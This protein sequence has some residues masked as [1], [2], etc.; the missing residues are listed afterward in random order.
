MKDSHT[1]VLIFYFLYARTILKVR[2]IE[3]TG[4]QA[5]FMAGN[6]AGRR[7]VAALCL[8]S[9][10]SRI[11]QVLRSYC[12]DTGLYGDMPFSR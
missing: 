6:E 5:N 8:P 10:V 2:Q 11:S 1:G 9:L 12:L 7:R 3:P 4:I